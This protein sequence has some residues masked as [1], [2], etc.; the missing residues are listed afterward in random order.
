MTEVL[1]D[2]APGRGVVSYRGLAP[3]RVPDSPRNSTL[4]PE[5]HPFVL[6]LRAQAT[7]TDGMVEVGAAAVP[8]GGTPRK[9]AGS[10]GG[11]N[12]R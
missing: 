12:S 10:A 6:M 3:R 11:G 7:Y 9:C 2:A 5:H 8:A 4:A 1:I